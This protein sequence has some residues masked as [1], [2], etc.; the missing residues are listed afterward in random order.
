MRGDDDDR[1]LAEVACF[2]ETLEK[3]PAVDV[4]H[5][6][7]EK[8]DVRMMNVQRALSFGAVA[9]E[10]NLESMLAQRRRE[11]AAKRKIVIDDEHALLLDVCDPLRS[12]IVPR[13]QLVHR[14]S[15]C[16]QVTG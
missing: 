16:T 9:G 13:L 7:I 14:R 12:R 2:L 10:K 15:N 4:G 11:H 8:H 6:E 3:V 5:G 1:D